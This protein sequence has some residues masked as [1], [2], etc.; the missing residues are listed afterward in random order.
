ME[1]KEIK[2]EKQNKN[3]EIKNTKKKSWFFLVFFGIFL[4]ILIFFIIF[5]SFWFLTI[6]KTITWISAE[7]V[8]KLKKKNWR[9]NIL[10]VWRWWIRNDAPNLTDSIILLSIIPD[11]KY[12]VMLSIPRD[13]YVE[14]LGKRKWKL[15]EVY[16]RWLQRY[17]WNKQKA[18]KLLEEKIEQITWEKI[19]YYVNLDFNWFVKIVDNLWWLDIV[20]PK[21]IIDNKYPK[22]IWYTTFVLTKWKK[23]ISWEIALKYARSRHS[24]SDFD[25]SLRQQIIIKAL[26]KKIEDLGFLDRVWAIKD[27]YNTY[28]K[29]LKTDLTF[30]EVASLWLYL[31]EIPK[32]NILSFN[33]N[34][35]CSFWYL[36][37]ETWGFL[38]TPNREAFWWL[39]VLLPK[40]AYYKNISYYDEIQKFT[41]LIFNYP[42]FF[43]QKVEIWF[44]NSVW[45]P[46]L[47]T[48]FVWDLKKYWFKVDFKNIW[49]VKD[50]EY[51]ESVIYFNNI[52]QDNKVLVILSFFLFVDLEKKQQVQFA[53]N[54]NTKIE[55]IIWK[56]Y[57]DLLKNIE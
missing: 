54:P 10:I 39:S 1:K 17:R 36:R 57:K 9:I 49:N 18:M 43:K 53:K 38:Y 40:W 16:V 37:C 29:Y 35:S 6:T 50:K 21:T 19:N 4:V 51:D 13:L 24:T 34:N 11:K 42:E 5:K 44:L 30:K 14:Y 3:L 26:R 48:R 15:N 8:K 32:E 56:D 23:H 55:F 52:K 41:N 20:V 28:K 31:K 27:F 45:V 2:I 46:G 7:N 47:A 25:R 33:L 22:W 12:I